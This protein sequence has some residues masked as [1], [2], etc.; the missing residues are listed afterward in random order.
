VNRADLVAA[1]WDGIRAVEPGAAVRRVLA[2]EAGTV[3]VDGNPIGRFQPS[4]IVVFGIGKAAVAMADAVAE[5]TGATRG[6]IVTPYEGSSVIPTMRGGHPIP[7]SSSFEA[8]RALIELAESVDEGDLVVAV[9][10]GGGSAAVEV[11]V[12]GV[13]PADIAAMNH[14]LVDSGAPIGD[15]NEVRSAVSKF[16]AGGLRTHL[17]TDHLV[18]LVLSDIAD[19]GSHLVASGP[20][21]W[22]GLGDRAA[23]VVSLHGLADVLPAGV[24]EAANRFERRPQVVGDLVVEVGSPLVAGRAAVASLKRAGI[25]AE[26]LDKPLEGDT[27]SAVGAF[28]DSLRPGSAIVGVGETT[29]DVDGVG[30][31]GRNQH[32]A[33]LASMALEGSG[34]FFAAFGTDGIDGRTR[35][36]GAVVNG[37]TVPDLRSSGVDPAKV[38]SLFDSHTALASVGATVETGPTG[39]NVADLW[40]GFRLI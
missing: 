25:D 21:V 26:L 3:A 27:A 18:T 7:D 31:G 10:S 14:V 1:F 9:V 24:V 20:T 40:I 30:V 33:L 17:L 23:D 16:K 6:I 4:R 12:D 2:Y 34:G 37:S 5:V 28:L 22:S 11:S 32:A 39:T 35:A 8:G 36:A 38:V 29:V 15:I 13:S 19:G